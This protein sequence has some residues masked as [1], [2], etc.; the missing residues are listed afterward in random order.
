MN[1]QDNTFFPK[2]F[3]DQPDHTWP[4][5]SATERLAEYPQP[6]RRVHAAERGHPP[7]PTDLGW[8][9]LYNTT[10]P[11]PTETGLFALFK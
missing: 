3:I 2:L 8:G 1:L 4:G 6:L 5:S 7:R 9:M 11:A 10:Q